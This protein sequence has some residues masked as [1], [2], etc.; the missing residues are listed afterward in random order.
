[1]FI[2]ESKRNSIYAYNIHKNV[3]T[4]IHSKNISYIFEHPEEVFRNLKNT[5]KIF[6]KIHKSTFKARIY[7]NGPVGKSS[8]R[9]SSPR[10]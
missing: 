9:N 3:I 8:N 2:I 10:L 7:Y 6:K 5:R 4:Q 1:M